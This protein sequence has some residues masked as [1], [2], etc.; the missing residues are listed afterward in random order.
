[1]LSHH[2][3]DTDCYALAP[4][5][6][7]QLVLYAAPVHA[8]HACRAHEFVQLSKLGSGRAVLLGHSMSACLSLGCNTALADA[9][10]LGA[11]VRAVDGDLAAAAAAFTAARLPEVEAL[12]EDMRDVHAVAMYP[13]Q[14]TPPLPAPP[15]PVPM[16]VA[17]LERVL[18]LLW[19]LVHRAAPGAP[20][21]PSRGDPR[22]LHHLEV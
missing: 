9:A 19:N 20:P 18:A 13:L 2:C 3:S 10:A 21:P 1:M 16:L 17:L 5:T 14:A 4:H 8:A 7:S 15:V 22:R 11:A 12:Q 6:S